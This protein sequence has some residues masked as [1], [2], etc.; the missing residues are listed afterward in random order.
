MIQQAAGQ[1]QDLATGVNRDLSGNELTRQIQV[2]AIAIDEEQ[3]Q[4]APTPK[5]KAAT[6]GQTPQTQA[7]AEIFGTPISFAKTLPELL[8]GDKWQTRRNWSDGHAAKFGKAY[9]EGKLVRA[10]DKDRRVPGSKQVGLLRLTREPYEQLLADITSAEIAAEGF[11]AMSRQKFV[12]EFFDGEEEQTLWVLEFEFIPDKPTNPEASEPEASEPEASE[13]EAET[14]EPHPEPEPKTPSTSETPLPEP[15]KSPNATEGTEEFKGTYAEELQETDRAGLMAAIRAGEVLLK[16][17]KMFKGQEQQEEKSFGNWIKR[18]GYSVSWGYTRMKL[19]TTYQDIANSFEE[20]SEVIGL[21]NQK[22]FFK[23]ADQSEEFKAWLIEKI[24]NANFLAKFAPTNRINSAALGKIKSFWTVE[25]SEI[26]P[27]HLKG[28]EVLH[29]E[30]V[31]AIAEVAE[32]A[33][34]LPEQFKEHF[35]AALWE[36]DAQDYKEIARSA[37]EA[38]NFMDETQALQFA[39]SENEDF[40]E[41]VLGELIRTGVENIGSKLSK[42]AA[43]VEKLCAQLFLAH[44]EYQHLSDRLYV[45]TG[46]STP[47]TRELLKS[48][49]QNLGPDKCSIKLGLENPEEVSIYFNPPQAR[50]AAEPDAASLQAIASQIEKV[51]DSSGLPCAV[52]GSYVKISPE[53]KR[54]AGEVAK[55]TDDRNQQS[56][57][58]TIAG[59]SVEA[60]FSAEELTPYKPPQEKVSMSVIE[61]SLAKLQRGIRLA[62]YREADMFHDLSAQNQTLE[63]EVRSQSERIG[64]LQTG[65]A[66]AQALQLANQKLSQDLDAAREELLAA[67]EADQQQQSA[68]ELLQQQKEKELRIARTNALVSDDASEKIEALREQWAGEKDV[69]MNRLRNANNEVDALQAQKAQLQA[70]LATLP[71]GMTNTADMESAIDV[72]VRACEKLG[73]VP[74]LPS[75]ETITATMEAIRGCGQGILDFLESQETWQ[76]A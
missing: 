66:S 33:E 50:P 27:E 46:A 58:V 3:T 51:F 15:N 31:K 36:A 11:P 49:G 5:A 44:R 40:A 67:Q 68:L 6:E 2:E 76:A 52:K 17:R 12:E 28:N 42:A 47:K 43:K 13:P 37:K 70:Q 18:Q 64:N 24:Q 14:N 65:T 22:T 53:A 73:I 19:A 10:F 30:E 9:R 61:G 16:A 38:F 7:E 72:I 54:Y 56:I 34:A 32:K 8:S 60:T 45:E 1:Q 48:L 39:S 59:N 4:A 75:E 23:F 55:V 26:V 21:F 29:P 20:I 41:G 69:I 74:R 62:A 57:E 71:D 63:E 35:A 25:N